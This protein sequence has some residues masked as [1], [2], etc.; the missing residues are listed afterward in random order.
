MSYYT[1]TGI[2]GPELKV[3]IRAIMEPILEE[4]GSIR[5]IGVWL[6]G[7]FNDQRTG[8]ARDPLRARMRMVKGRARRMGDEL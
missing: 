4:N 2:L 8:H 7:I 3:G 6:V 5:R 1:L